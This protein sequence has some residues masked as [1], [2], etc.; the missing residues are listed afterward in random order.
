MLA[1]SMVEATWDR[2]LAFLADPDPD[3]GSLE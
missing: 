1:V 2:L 3:E